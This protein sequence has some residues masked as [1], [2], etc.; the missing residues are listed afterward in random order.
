MRG[1][2]LA[3]TA[4]AQQISQPHDFL[5]NERHFGMPHIESLPRARKAK[6]QYR[7]TRKPRA[8]ILAHHELSQMLNPERTRPGQR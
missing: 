5:T 3:D 7:A 8:A 2:V 4:P 6:R 1:G